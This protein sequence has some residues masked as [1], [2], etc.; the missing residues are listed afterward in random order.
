MQQLDECR[1][2]ATCLL[3]TEHARTL[4]HDVIAITSIAALDASIK[5]LVLHMQ[6]HMLHRASLEARRVVGCHAV[7]WLRIATKA[8][9]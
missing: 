6:R 4:A 3:A 5:F 9:D 1:L 7:A 2:F 8:S